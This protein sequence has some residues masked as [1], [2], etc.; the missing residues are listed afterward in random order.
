MASTSRSSSSQASASA[1]TYTKVMN[2]RDLSR[3]DDFISHLLVEKVGTRGIPLLVHKM[4]A[5]RCLPKTNV[6]DLMAIVQRVVVCKGHPHAV[7]RSA[8]NELLSL[9]PVRY[10]TQPFTQKELN[11]FATHAS[12]YFELYLPTGSIEI[13]HTE[14]YT[15]RTR[16]SELCIIATR[17]LAPGTVITELKGSMADLTEEEDQELKTATNPDGSSRKDFSVIH[18]KQLKKNH[19]FLGPARF[20]NDLSVRD[21]RTQRYRRVQATKRG[22][23]FV[24]RRSSDVEARANGAK[25]EVNVNER[26]TRRGVYAVLQDSD[27]EESDEEEE[28]K[29]EKG[30][31]P[32]MELQAEVEVDSTPIVPSSSS[33]PLRSSSTAAKA[34]MTPDPESSLPSAAVTPSTRENG[35]WQ[36]RSVAPVELVISTRGQKAR[37]ASL[38][39]QVPL[40]TPPL[41]DDTASPGPGTRAPYA[42]GAHFGPV[43][44][45]ACAGAGADEKEK[46]AKQKEKDPNLPTCVTCSKVL[47]IISLDQRVIW[48]D[49]DNVTG[50]G[51]GKRKEKRECPRCLRH[52]AI[53]GFSWP[54]RNAAQ[55]AAFVPTPRETTPAESAPRNVTQ[56]ILPALDKKLSVAASSVPPKRPRE[57]SMV[58][59]ESTPKRRKIRRTIIHTSPAAKKITAAMPSRFKRTEG[60][61]FASSSKFTTSVPLPLKRKRGRPPL[62]IRSDPTTPPSASAP[63]GLQKTGSRVIRMGGLERKRVATGGAVAAGSAPDNQVPKEEPEDQVVGSILTDETFMKYAGGGDEPLWYDEDGNAEYTRES[64]RARLD[65]SDGS[66]S[67]DDEDDEDEEDEEPFSFWGGLSYH[68]NPVSFARRKWAPLLPK[69]EKPFV[70]RHENQHSNS[71]SSGHEDQSDEPVTPEDHLE[72]PD[73][74]AIVD[75]PDA[76]DA[77]QDHLVQTDVAGSV[78][79]KAVVDQ[80][81]DDEEDDEDEDEEIEEVEVSARPRVR[82]FSSIGAIWKPSPV[83]FAKK[84][85]LEK[86]DQTDDRELEN[87]RAAGSSNRGKYGLKMLDIWE[88]HRRAGRDVEQSG[89]PTFFRK[90][91][92]NPRAAHWDLFDLGSSSSGEED[93]VLPDSPEPSKFTLK[94]RVS[95]GPRSPV[96]H[97]ASP[98]S[99]LIDRDFVDDDPVDADRIDGYH[100]NSVPRQEDSS[101][102]PVKVPVESPSAGGTQVEVTETPPIEDTQVEVTEAP[103]VTVRQ[104]E[105]EE[106]SVDED[107][108]DE[109]QIQKGL[110]D[111]A[112]TDSGVAGDDQIGERL[113]DKN[114]ID[115][116]A[117]HATAEKLL[118]GVETIIDNL[119]KATNILM[120]DY[121]PPLVIFHLV[122]SPITAALLKSTKY[123]SKTATFPPQIHAP[124]AKLVEAP[125]DSDA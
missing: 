111:D 23:R 101:E 115:L 61:L 96:A 7:I 5:A 99:D 73:D 119:R 12:R 15:Y 40:P 88:A 103:R 67:E 41:S 8:V 81:E 98:I 17:P 55:A 105:V 109:A 65:E 68:P 6:E 106:N 91:T 47:P 2:F 18:S 38:A 94:P 14:R 84:R 108:L 21:V 58:T 90:L 29:Q 85:W 49:F 79:E 59:E 77:E 20:V 117:A 9:A 35:R 121:L 30:E 83:N 72:V 102:V 124:P 52:F 64:K 87:T 26:R 46:K 11:A 33:A 56:K 97:P 76:D 69:D 93:V 125:W 51:K 4:D 120:P 122:Q 53:Y 34:L 95:F 116:I 66:S 63:P 80:I 22:S 27:V 86:T 112:S 110:V 54:N 32:A 13:S 36:T 19:L 118:E 82:S 123:S 10:Y 37:A 92:Q 74:F 1:W 113:A 104:A 25:P 60:G 89:L 107:K 3:D 43:A 42:H 57:S 28:Q 75:G 39:A 45:A 44:L 78:F 62:H 100:A 50:K 24:G 48:G 71:S 31:E 16:K 114:P 70:A